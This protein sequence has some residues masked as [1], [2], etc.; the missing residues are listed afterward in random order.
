MDPLHNKI[1]I[2]GAGAIGKA[3]AIFLK[4]AG[5]DVTLIRGTADDLPDES[6]SLSCV[7]NDGSQLT[8]T[9]TIS[10]FSQHPQMNGIIVLT[11]KSIG[12][13]AI[14]Q[15]I[16]ERCRES[17]VVILQNGLDIER[18]F[19]EKNIPN[20]YRCVLLATSQETSLNTLRFKP[21]TSSPI[22]VV[23]GDSQ[24]VESIVT[25]L[26]T[27]HFPFRTEADIQKLVWQKVIANCVFNSI[28]PLLDIDNGIF[29]RD[30]S[31][32]K[33]AAEVIDECVA[34]AS[35]EGFTLNSS[36]VMKTVLQISQ[37]SDGQLISTL[38]DIR[39]KRPTE[40]ESLNFAIVK[41]AE[42]HGMAES[43]Q[44]T[45]LLGELTKQKSLLNLPV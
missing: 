6:V 5:R 4:N 39:R 20:I 11:N 38:Q 26:N 17:P 18:A 12:N 13:S 28:C 43:I 2:V 21:V 31:A 15:I 44:K 24:K 32:R 9:V 36:D 1:Y 22:G 35:S 41:I 40:I 42:R 7:L 8:A 23:K 16:Y 10:T 19:V 34:V 14:S 3:L 30:E 29:Y 33:L 37:A 45:A 27:E 25:L